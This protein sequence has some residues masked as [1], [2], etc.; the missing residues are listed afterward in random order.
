MQYRP[1]IDGL[2]AVA[3][4]CV[5]LFHCDFE[6][7][8]GGYI[9]VDVFFVISGFLIT[10]L[11]LMDLAKGRFSFAR[12]YTR[13]ARRLLPALL[14][15]VVL[16]LAAAT[17]IMGPEDLVDTAVSGGLAAIS[18]SNFY[19]AKAASYFDAS[20]NAK[21]FLHMWSLSL[22]EQYYLFWPLTVFMVYRWKR[23]WAVAAMIAAAIPLG[24]A[25][26]Q[27]WVD[28]NVKQAYF[29]LPF[30]G[31]QFLLGAACIWLS[32]VRISSSGT[33][34][35]VGMC[36]LALIAFSAITF[37]EGTPFPGLAALVPS[38]GAVLV[39][40]QGQQVGMQR[41]IGNRPLA[42]F[43]RISYSTYLVHWPIIV[44]WRYLSIESLSLVDKV[45]LFLLSV[46]GGQLLYS[47]VEQRF[48]YEHGEQPRSTP[49][50]LVGI[51]GVVAAVAEE[52]PRFRTFVA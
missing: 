28:R 21:P 5:L 23:E 38:L 40:W 47:L 14:A 22:E 32:R 12:F 51:T 19:F 16:V 33:G 45:T 10:S 24:L 15:T 17:V 31:F 11:I 46:A 25:L 7:F 20:A 8:S 49:R 48:R 37:S 1:D 41:L 39:I 27:Y 43:G 3:I 30:R 29:L 42:W 52:A 13:R 35:L 44:F 4:L 34:M 6:W 9:G 36:G 26:S 2:R 18:L 50:F